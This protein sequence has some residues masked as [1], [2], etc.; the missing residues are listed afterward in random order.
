[1]NKESILVG[2]IIAL[3]VI[4]LVFALHWRASQIVLNIDEQEF[5]VGENLGGTLSIKIEPGDSLKKDIPI[6]IS[7][8]KENETVAATTLTLEEFIQASNNP[9]N[10]ILHDNDYYYETPATHIVNI[11]KILTYQFTKK[12]QYEL[13]FNILSIGLTVKRTIIVK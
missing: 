6:L 1:M 10:P 2:V 5:N 13:L 11:D 3:I 9:S 8:S 7:L 4:V 12:G